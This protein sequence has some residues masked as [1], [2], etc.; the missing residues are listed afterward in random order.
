MAEWETVRRWS[1]AVIAGTG[2]A[3]LSMMGPG[4]ACAVV[5]ACCLPAGNCQMLRRG[6]R[7]SW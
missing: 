4:E 2:S 1:L 7:M 5:R 3:L 6:V